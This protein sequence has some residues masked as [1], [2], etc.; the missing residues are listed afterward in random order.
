MINKF[1]WI[2]KMQTR[3]NDVS[4][5][6]MRVQARAC[7]S[8]ESMYVQNHF[9]RLRRFYV[10]GSAVASI[11]CI[12]WCRTGCICINLYC[13]SSLLIYAHAAHNLLLRNETNRRKLWRANQGKMDE[14]ENEVIARSSWCIDVRASNWRASV[15]AIF[16][17][18]IS[19]ESY[20]AH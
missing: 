12:L 9:R 2:W 7:V 17:N 3:K 5:V 1:L 10:S 20:R 18:G 19:F 6:H 11:S 16:E 4:F 13:I 8:S 15:R 14:W